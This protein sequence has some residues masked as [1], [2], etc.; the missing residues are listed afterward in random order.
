MIEHFTTVEGAAFSCPN[1]AAERFDGRESVVDCHIGGI[2]AEKSLIGLG[3]GHGIIESCIVDTSLMDVNINELD[4][5][6]N[7]EG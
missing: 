2:V 3:C 7:A 4:T 5:P 6:M 1:T